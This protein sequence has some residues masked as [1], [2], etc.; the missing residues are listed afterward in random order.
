[1]L[2]KPSWRTSRRVHVKEAIHSIIPNASRSGKPL[3]SPRREM[4]VWRREYMAAD[5]I[6]PKAGE[7]LLV[8]RTMGA[9]PDIRA[10]ARALIHYLMTVSAAGLSPASPIR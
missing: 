2:D 6:L 8:S 9:S 3:M 7:R 5:V 4:L 10:L 1:M